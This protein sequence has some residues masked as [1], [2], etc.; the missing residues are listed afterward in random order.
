M[1]KRYSMK[2]RFIKYLTDIYL[3]VGMGYDSR[4]ECPE[5]FEAI[6][7]ETNLFRAVIHQ[8]VVRI[9]FSQAIEITDKNTLMNLLVLYGK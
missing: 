4:N 6:P 7:L 2:F 5:F 8:H 3:V 1:A 9:P